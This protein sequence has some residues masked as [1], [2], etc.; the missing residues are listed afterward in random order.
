MSKYLSINEL[1]LS[2][3][4]I[5]ARALLGKKLIY[6]N[7]DT[8]LSGYIVETEAYHSDDPASHSFGGITKS[9]SSL[10]MNAGTIYVYFTYGMHFCLNVVTGEE[11][12]GQAV[13]LRAIQPV[14]GIE[15]MKRN[16][17]TDKFINLT[18]GP[19]KLTQALGINKSINGTNIINGP[20]FLAE[21]IKPKAIVVDTRIGISRAIDYP[22]RFYIKDS[23]FVSKL[24]KKVI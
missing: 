12:H 20:I 19:A 14:D 6:K 11:G 4:V 22:W 2:N 10:F 21:G 16:R 23:Q 7:N 15:I 17:K 24:A 3:S 5:A 8:Q 9:N 18:N 1:E 13:L